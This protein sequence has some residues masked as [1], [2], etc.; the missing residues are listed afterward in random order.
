[1]LVSWPN[2]DKSTEAYLQVF[3]IFGRAKI[4]DKIFSNETQRN[5]DVSQ[6]PNGIYLLKIN[7]KGKS[8]F[9]TNLIIQR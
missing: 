9:Q 7:S 6:F 3:D 1:V 4:N 5:F 8:L 2:W